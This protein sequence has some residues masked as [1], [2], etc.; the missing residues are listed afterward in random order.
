M[1]EQEARWVEPEALQRLVRLGGLD[2]LDQMM[3]LLLEAGP[4]RIAAARDAVAV[5]DMDG[6]RRAAHS[7]KSSAGNLGLIRLQRL[8][9]DVEARAGAGEED[10]AAAGVGQLETVYLESVRT[11][12]ALREG[13]G[14][15]EEPDG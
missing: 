14:D 12:K 10:A 6:A 2:L 5:G 3:A 11:L 15:P 8:A 9:Q 7:L 1:A 4:Q 13:M